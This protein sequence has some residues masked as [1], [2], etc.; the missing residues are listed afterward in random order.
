M[1]ALGEIRTCLLRNSHAVPRP[2]VLELLRLVPG[3][4]VRLSERPVAH[5]VSPPALSGVDCSLPTA[6]GARYR[7]VGTIGARAVITSGRVLQGSAYVTVER[8][9]TDYRM[10]WS[11]YLSMPG[12]VQ[13]IGKFNAPDVVDGFLANSAPAATL[14]LGAVSERRIS[15]V[16]A[17]P[18]LDHTL[19]LRAS[20][21]RFRWAARISHGSGGG[22]CEFVVVDEAVRTVRLTLPAIDRAEVIGFC[23]DLALHD[24]VLS[25]VLR[26]VERS[27]TRPV[28]ELRPAIDHLL[29]LWMPGAHVS[30]SLLPFWES[31]E[32]RP[33]FTRQWETMVSHIRDRLMST[34]VA[35]RNS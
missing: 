20:R 26:W 31:L 24:W 10:P 11:H 30:E 8:G 15:A 12:V 33:G 17:Q 21:T 1:L 4:R 16:Q 14:D 2:S 7:T 23:E 5:G 28:E 22:T 3:Q 9:T 29:N 27:G 34:M 25:T 32:R 35:T 18:G 13:T 19:P 6:S